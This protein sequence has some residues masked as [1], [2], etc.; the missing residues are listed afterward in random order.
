[1]LSE[2]SWIS[3]S[4]RRS[5]RKLVWTL[6]RLLFLLLLHADKSRGKQHIQMYRVRWLILLCDGVVPSMHRN[7]SR[8]K[9]C[10]CSSSVKHKMLI[11]LRM[12]LRDALKGYPWCSS[13][14]RKSWNGS[15]FSWDKVLSTV[16][17]A[18]PPCTY[19]SLH[20]RWKLNLLFLRLLTHLLT[21]CLMRGDRQILQRS[22]LP[23]G[24]EIAR[25]DKAFAFVTIPSPLLILSVCYWVSLD[26]M[27]EVSEG[28]LKNS[29]NNNKTKPL[30]IPL[31]AFCWKT[32]LWQWPRSTE[33]FN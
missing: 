9:I 8:L 17:L 29:N 15:L 6:C 3:S 30:A 11:S 13:F 25:F 14:C 22:H 33:V 7:I 28:F 10:L 4:A 2:A 21:I 24:W 12:V 16:A 18:V 27:L 1:M 20:C 23:W 5:I 31:E 32:N 26:M 19:R